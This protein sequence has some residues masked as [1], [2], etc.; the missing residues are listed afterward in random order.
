[1]YIQNRSS[2]HI[3]GV[4]IPTSEPSTLIQVFQNNNYDAFRKYIHNAIGLFKYKYDAYIHPSILFSMCVTYNKIRN[5]HYKTIKHVFTSQ[6]YNYHHQNKIV[7]IW[8]NKY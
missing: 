7:S 8:N 1:M 5:V 2:S 6:Q 3:N 4:R